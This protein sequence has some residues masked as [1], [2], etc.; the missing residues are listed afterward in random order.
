MNSIATILIL[1]TFSVSTLAQSLRNNSHPNIH[2]CPTD[3]DDIDRVSK[4]SKQFRKI[5]F[6]SRYNDHNIIRDKDNN[7]R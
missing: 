5:P 3:I 1:G 4:F 7:K 2:L 6:Q